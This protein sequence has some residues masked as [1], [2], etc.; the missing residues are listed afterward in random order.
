[1]K[2]SA[3]NTHGMNTEISTG[4][5]FVDTESIPWT[6]FVMDGMHFKLLDYD[7][8]R[9]TLFVKIDK[10]TTLAIHQHLAP[11]EFFLLE[12]SFGYVDEATGKESIIRKMGYMFEPPGTAHR[13]IS[14]DGCIGFSVLHGD[15]RGFDDA[16]NPV[17]IGPSE[18]YR[19]A[20][21]NNAVS[22]LGTP[23]ED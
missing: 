11:V 7:E 17:E 15:I 19:R 2:L 23:E 1:M 13:P 22:H 8:D 4:S 16:G 21:L 20:K 5:R 12:G 6:P 3:E 9:C 10:G 18:Y 14:P